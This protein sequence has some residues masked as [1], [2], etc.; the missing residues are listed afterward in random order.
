MSEEKRIFQ[1]SEIKQLTRKKKIDFLEKKNSIWF[2][3]FFFTENKFLASLVGPK[4]I[5]FRPKGCE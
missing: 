3:F 2:F 5:R 4:G 1:Q